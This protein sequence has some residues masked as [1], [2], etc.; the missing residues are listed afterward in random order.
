MAFLNQRITPFLLTTTAFVVVALV[1]ILAEEKTAIHLS[2]NSVHS[3]WA[4][5]FFK[6]GTEFGNGITCVAIVGLVAVWHRRNVLPV[7]I[8]GIASYA[9][10]GLLVQALKR[11]VFEDALRPIRLIAPEKLHLV[12]GVQ[13]HEYFTFPSG[14]SA[15]TAVIVTFL[16]LV[17]K[18]STG[19]QITLAL[20]GITGAFSRVY[21]SQH[22]LVDSLAGLVIG[23]LITLM[24]YTL[25]KKYTFKRF[26]K[27]EA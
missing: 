20:V 17:S 7:L 4:D 8:F 25:M 26:F 11:F 10:A 21:I 6:Y 1:V 18:R 13:L 14:H 3:N 24:I 2:M 9:I 27:S 15:T 22:F 16:A 19:L 12:E 5:N 23:V